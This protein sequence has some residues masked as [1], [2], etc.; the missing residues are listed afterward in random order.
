MG[1]NKGADEYVRSVYEVLNR[2]FG[3]TSTASHVSVKIEQFGGKDICRIDVEPLPKIRDG[4]LFIIERSDIRKEKRFYVRIGSSSQRQ[5]MESAV[6]Y[7][8][9]NFPPPNDSASL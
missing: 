9:D 4:Q 8:R 5:S 3:D 6:R 1:R 2:G 7:I